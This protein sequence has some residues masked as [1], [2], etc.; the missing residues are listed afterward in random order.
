VKENVC[1]GVL[2]GPESWD[3]SLSLWL[4]CPCR[5]HVL[6]AFNAEHLAWLEAYVSAN[7]RERKHENLDCKPEDFCRSN[8]SLASRLPKWMTSA[9]NRE[10]VLNSIK[11]LKRRLIDH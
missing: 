2:G 10:D 3:I 9:K 4:K 7:H 5:G 6:W 11:K 8:S 1:W